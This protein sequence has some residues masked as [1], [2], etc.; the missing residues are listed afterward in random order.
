MLAGA[1]TNL[2][3]GFIR[4]G[5]L[6]SAVNASPSATAFTVSSAT[7]FVILGQALIGPTM[8]FGDMALVESIRSGQV[9][10]E[11]HRPWDWSIYRLAH[12]SAG[13]PIRS[14]AAHW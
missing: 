5:V 6:R 2:I 1:F 12:A 10:T 14:S 4:G 11:L 3:F 9:A 7:V 8:L 13:L